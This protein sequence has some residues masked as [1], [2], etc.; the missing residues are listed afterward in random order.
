MRW[1][2]RFSFIF[3]VCLF[4]SLF[5]LSVFNIFFGFFAHSMCIG[6]R[7]LGGLHWQ[8]HSGDGR[9]FHGV[10]QFSGAVRRRGY[11]VLKP[12]RVKGKESCCFCIAA[13][14]EKNKKAIRLFLSSEGNAQSAGNGSIKTKN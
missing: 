13:R 7:L 9:L 6:L 10:M 14:R 3:Y 12:R 11:G 5:L 8:R 1:S 4:E 2:T